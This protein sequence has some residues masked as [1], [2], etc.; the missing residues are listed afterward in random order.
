MKFGAAKS[1]SMG[2][3]LSALVIGVSSIFMFEEGSSAYTGSAILI[4]LLFVAS[5]LIMFIWGR[6]PYCGKHL[7]YGLYKWKTCPKCRRELSAN[8]KYTPSNRIKSKHK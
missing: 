1:A 8:D 5:L 4:I 6:C 3:L 7:F 2:M